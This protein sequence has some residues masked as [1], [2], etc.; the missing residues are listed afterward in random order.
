M[1]AS[2][3]NMEA[4]FKGDIMC[5]TLFKLTCKSATQGFILG[6]IH[7]EKFSSSAWLTVLT[8]LE[9]VSTGHNVYQSNYH[10]DE[11]LQIF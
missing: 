9:N 3:S 2:Y 6:F 11:K 8:A 4:D 5:N 1:G 10:V 7:I